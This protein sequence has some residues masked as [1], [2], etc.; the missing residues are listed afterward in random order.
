MF[1]IY[2]G[3]KLRDGAKFCTSCGKPVKTAG[4][5][6]S[7]TTANTDVNLEIKE[8]A[9]DLAKAGAKQIIAALKDRDINAPATPGEVSCKP[10]A[11]Q[12]AFMKLL[13]K[14]LPVLIALFAMPLAMTAQNKLSQVIGPFTVSLNNGNPALTY[15]IEFEGAVASGEMFDGGTTYF[16]SD[17]KTPHTEI[18][19]YFHSK[20]YITMK[21]RV[22]EDFGVV[23]SWEVATDFG[24]AEKLFRVKQNIMGESLVSETRNLSKGSDAIFKIAVPSADSHLYIHLQV[25]QKAADGYRSWVSQGREIILASGDA[26]GQTI[27]SDAGSA[28]ENEWVVPA[29]VLGGLAAGGLALKMRKKKKSKDKDSARKEQEKKSDKKDTKDEEKDDDEEKAT[30]EM[31]IRKDFGDTLTPGAA[32]QKVYARIV[33][34]PQG[35]A[36][37]TD[38]ALTAKIS[39]TGDGYLNVSG[40]SLAGDYMSASVEA[41]QRGS[42]PDEAV[43]NFRLASGGG[44]FTNRMHFKLAK[45][46]IIFFQENLTLPACSDEVWRLPFAVTGVSKNAAVEACS[47][48]LDKYNVKIEPGEKDGL[49]YAIISEKVKDKKEPGTWE[50]FSLGIKVLNGSTEMSDSIP[51]YRFHMGLKFAPHSTVPCYLQKGEVKKA[52]AE[53]V[54]FDWDPETNDIVTIFPV[55]K[56]FKITA[57]DEKNRDILTSWASAVVRPLPRQKTDAVLKYTL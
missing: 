33:R 7:A 51:L 30:Y 23:D 43:V 36:A 38:P 2:C 3:T 52:C 25:R 44:S 18:N 45:N 39:I 53:L 8:K 32:A 49:Y 55:P 5:P 46:E 22:E 24:E 4:K 16:P 6:D 50:P 19:G 15:T 54:Y 12:N 47:N 26:V 1:C 28:G 21:V 29:V 10:D 9:L 41:P 13:K 27:D 14:G 35:G 20:D 42:I 48:C 56:D 11:A 31:R 57:E 37:A 34:I 40:Q 17:G